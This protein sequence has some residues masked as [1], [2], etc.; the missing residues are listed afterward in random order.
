MDLADERKAPAKARTTVKKAAAKPSPVRQVRKLAGHKVAQKP[1][2]GLRY[3]A[4]ESPRRV[5][6][7][8]LLGVTGARRGFMT[9]KEWVDMIRQGIPSAAVDTLTG[10]LLISQAEF[11]SALDI[12]VRT[13]VR[14]KGSEALPRDESEKLVRV[15]R[16]IERAEDVFEDTDAARDWLKSAN[17]SLGGDTPMSLLDTEIGAGSVMDALGRIEHGVFA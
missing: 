3:G 7:A 17:A 5:S 1:G 14:R 11:S 15:A 12:P 4:M 2:K 16:V 13:L 10:F 9:P 6:A 8:S